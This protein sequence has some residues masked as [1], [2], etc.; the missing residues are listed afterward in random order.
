MD[1]VARN[2]GKM[3]KMSIFDQ[4]CSNMSY[5]R[6]QGWKT[7]KIRTFTVILMQLYY[8]NRHTG[9]GVKEFRFLPDVL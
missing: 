4:K 2:G 6:V 1:Q 7:Q 9:E 8:L 5:S 3:T